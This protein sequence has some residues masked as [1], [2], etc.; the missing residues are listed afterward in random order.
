VNRYFYGENAQTLAAESESRWRDWLSR[1]FAAP[2]AA[3]T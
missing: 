1:M 3:A 2:A